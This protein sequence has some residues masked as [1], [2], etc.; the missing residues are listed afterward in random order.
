MTQEEHDALIKELQERVAEAKLQPEDLEEMIHDIFSQMA[1]NVNN[2]GITTQLETLV[3]S[4]G[5]AAKQEI[6][7][8]IENKQRSRDG[9]L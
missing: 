3:D 4:Y 2:D 7:N 1:S 9:N 5:T 8:I 6:E